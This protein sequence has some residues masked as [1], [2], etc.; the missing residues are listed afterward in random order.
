MKPTNYFK[1]RTPDVEQTFAFE[2]WNRGSIRAAFNR[3]TMFADG[4]K[5]RLSV[6][7][8]VP[9]SGP[10]DPVPSIVTLAAPLPVWNRPQ[11]MSAPAPR[12]AF[13]LYGEGGCW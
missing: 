9:L 2:T 3:A 7:Y 4:R 11:V 10:W 6:F 8:P 13:A 5:G 12:R 1:V